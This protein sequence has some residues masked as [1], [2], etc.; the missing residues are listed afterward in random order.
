MFA[1]AKSLKSHASGLKPNQQP[2]VADCYWR[3]F[4]YEMNLSRLRRGLFLPFPRASP[5]PTDAYACALS[6]GG[7][8]NPPFGGLESPPSKERNREGSLESAKN[9]IS[10]R[11]QLINGNNFSIFSYNNSSL[12]L[13]NLLMS[14][15]SP[16]NESEKIH[17]QSR[18]IFSDSFPMFAHPEKADQRLYVCA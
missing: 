11:I 8:S 6:E 7:F 12:I 15:N 17:R 3:I 16:T 9:W 1:A 4:T 10:Y 5:V 13:T 14:K 2:P 18:W